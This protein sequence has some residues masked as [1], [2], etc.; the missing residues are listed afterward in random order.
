MY[1]V[2]VSVPHV[3]YV[4]SSPQK[5]RQTGPAR[6]AFLFFLLGTFFGEEEEGGGVLF[7]QLLTVV[8]MTHQH[9]DYT[10]SYDIPFLLVRLCE[11]RGVGVCCCVGHLFALC[12][13]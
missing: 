1:F 12:I 4:S 3:M 5:G 7:I 6:W 8:M 10:V 11:I 13:F 2:S 9:Q